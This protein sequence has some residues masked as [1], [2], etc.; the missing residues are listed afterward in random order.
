MQ[1]AKVLFA[2]QGY[3]GTTVKQISEQAG[4]NISLISYHF[5]GKEGL[6][7]A[8]LEPLARAR[9]S[10]AQQVLVPPRSQEELRIRME[11]FLRE[12]FIGHLEEP[13]LCQIVARECELGIP[14][15]Q[16]L[17]KTTFL[18]IFE[19]LVS[20]FQAAQSLGFLKTA[21]D[22]EIVASVFFGGLFHMTAKDPLHEKFLGR[23]L[24]DPHYREQVIQ[25][26]L[27]FYLEGLLAPAVAGVSVQLPHSVEGCLP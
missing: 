3:D 11:L 19:T 27:N 2:S 10:I 1:T 15:A 17:F 25:N 18:K 6:Y 26:C 9:L 4:V 23:S 8:C 21:L 12:I 5:D 20:F 14:I 24:K 22:P 7:R 13:E 16:D